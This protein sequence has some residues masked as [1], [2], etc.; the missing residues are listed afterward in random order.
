MNRAVHIGSE[1]GA[2]L[3]DFNECLVPTHS[4]SVPVN[5]Q[6]KCQYYV[7]DALQLI[8]RIVRIVIIVIVSII[9]PYIGGE[10]IGGEGLRLI[11]AIL[12]DFEEGRVPLSSNCVPGN[13]KYESYCNIESLI[14]ISALQLHA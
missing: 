1:G 12:I 8:V 5:A 7:S 9:P 10:Y 4:K 6:E 14:A 2:L 11:N 3:I 13:S